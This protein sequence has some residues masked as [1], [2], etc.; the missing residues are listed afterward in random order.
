[1]SGL[2]VMIPTFRRPESFLRAARSVLRQVG[3]ANPPQLV[4]IDNSPEG[5]AAQ[6]FA[7]LRQETTA[8]LV[9]LHES[10][11]GVANARNA[12]MS[13]THGALVAFL[14]DDEEAPPHWLAALL[15][16]QRQT[17][18]DAVFG[19]VQARLANDAIPH[20]AYVERLY[21]RAGPQQSGPSHRYYGIGNSLLRRETMLAA[22]APFSLEANEKGGEDDMLF[23]WAHAAGRRFAWAAEAVVIE[24]IPPE[25]ANLAYAMKRA[26]A[27]GQGPCEAAFAAEP[28]QWGAIAAHMALGGAQATLCGAVAGAAFLAGSPARYWFLDKAVRGAGKLVWWRPRL[29]YGEAL[30]RESA[31]ASPPA[32][33][34]GGSP[35]SQANAGRLPSKT[36]TDRLMHRSGA[37]D[38]GRS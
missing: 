2:S 22:S 24:H 38:R 9:L 18:A 27:F 13:A 36:M 19:P 7:A 33:M 3:L 21:T 16:V 23:S 20:K 32:S 31:L 35:L 1:M 14:D 12:G 8:P 11:P 34:N 4:A 29:F 10:R 26:F 17:G 30:A 28:K 37:A 6:A 5:S 15:A 25:R